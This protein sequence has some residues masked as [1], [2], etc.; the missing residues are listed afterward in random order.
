MT[1]KFY[2]KCINVTINAIEG[3]VIGAAFVVGAWAVNAV[4]AGV[5]N[6]VADNV[7]L[8]DGSLAWVAAVVGNVAGAA[9]VVTSLASWV[10]EVALMVVAKFALIF[11]AI[12]YA[13][14]SIGHPS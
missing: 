7:M 4:V 14:A 6:A 3:A 1:I 12:A 10:V 13:Y 5:A 2:T 9:A 8:S 11:G